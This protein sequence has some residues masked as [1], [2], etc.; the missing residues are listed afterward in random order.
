MQSSHG[1]VMELGFYGDSSQH[2]KTTPLNKCEQ[3]SKGVFLQLV[4]EQNARCICTS[5]HCEE[6]CDENRQ[7]KTGKCHESTNGRMN[8]NSKRPYESPP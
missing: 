4:A 5:I 7:T 2:F 6:S 3:K 1:S 8:L